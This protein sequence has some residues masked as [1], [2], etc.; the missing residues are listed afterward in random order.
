[1]VLEELLVVS[2]IEIRQQEGIVHNNLFW[3]NRL[4]ISPRPLMHPEGMAIA[5]VVLQHVKNAG[6]RED[7]CF[8]VFRGEYVVVC[9][10]LGDVDGLVSICC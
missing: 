8:V 7:E 4:P 6:L 3:V 2:F 1:M 10:V 9:I 5:E